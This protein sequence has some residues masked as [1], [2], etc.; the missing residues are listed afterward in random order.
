MKISTTFSFFLILFLFTIQSIAQNVGI[1]VATPLQKL[2]VGGN[3]RVD[4]M[5]SPGTGVITTNAAGDLLRTNFS[6]NTNDVLKGNGTFGTVPG[7]LPSGAIVGSPNSNDA[8]LLAAGYSLYGDLETPGRIF[9][10]YPAMV[11]NQFTQAPTY[12]NGNPAKTPPPAG[13]SGAVGFWTG[14]EALVWGGFGHSGNSYYFFNDGSRYNPSTDSWNPISTVNAPSSRTYPLAV[15]TGTEMLIWGGLDS[16][17]LDIDGNATGEYLA[18]GG[19]YNPSTNTWT[20]ISTIGAPPS[21]WQVPAAW[22][23]TYMIIW[24]TDEDGNTTGARYNPATDTWSAIGTSPTAPMGSSKMFWTGTH[25]LVLNYNDSIGRYRASTN[26]WDATAI[27]PGGSGIPGAVVWTGTELL[28][29][30]QFLNHIYKYNPNSNTW[31]GPTPVGGTVVIASG[32]DLQSTVW[33]DTEMI[34]LGYVNDPDFPTTQNRYYRYNLVGNTFISTDNEMIRHNRF[35]QFDP[36]FFKAGNVLFKWGGYSQNTSDANELYLNMSRQGTRI[37]LSSG[38]SIP[39]IY[40]AGNNSKS[41]YLYQR[42]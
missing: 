36:L 35:V 26:S 33:T 39:I 29:Y 34:M 40:V 3:L 15:W 11:S 8:N 28:F 32:F 13:R 18:D 24:S 19:K 20:T 4:G 23:G 2:H 22:T 6:G 37:Y 38:I 7:G 25:V 30:D 41:L 1:G 17:I 31:T 21:R 42:N 16:I 9:S 10:T 14:N 27:Y 12:E 5:A